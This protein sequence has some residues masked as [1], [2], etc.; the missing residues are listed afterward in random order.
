[1]VFVAVRRRVGIAIAE[2]G[3]QDQAAL[4]RISGVGARKLELYGQEVL[5]VLEGTSAPG[6]R[7]GVAD[8]G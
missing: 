6:Q 8:D 1:M 2:S 5:T 7:R 3:A 4:S